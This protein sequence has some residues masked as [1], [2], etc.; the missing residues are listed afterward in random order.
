MKSA[1]NMP[2]PKIH[3]ALTDDWELRGNGSG[4]MRQIQF[5]AIREL[6]RIY[7]TYG[8]RSTF[9]VEV[10]Q[11]LTHRKRQGEFPE[12]GRLADE[13]DE[14]VRDAFK[15]GQ[16]I[17]LHVHPQ[18]SDA[19]YEGGRWTLS[20]DWSLPNY[21]AET[22][23]E[24]LS[25][26][27]KYLEDLLRPVDP[28]Y[29]VVSF[30][31]GSSSIAP[32]DFA[33]GLLVRLGLVFDMSIVGGLRVNTRNL[34]MDYTYCDEDLLPFYPRMD[35][36][37]K[38]S[39]KVEPIVCVPIFH[40]HLSRAQ[41]T[42]QVLAKMGQKVRGKLAN[43]DKRGAPG[44]KFAVDEWAEIG[45]SSRLA[46]LYDKAIKPCLAGKH[47]VAD[48]GQLDY[49]GLQAMI[50]AIRKRGRST[51]LAEVP[52][53]LTNHSK[54][55]KDFSAIERFVSEASKAADIR[56]VTLTQLAENLRAGKFP[57][58]TDAGS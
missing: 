53:I 48:I 30:R 3:L 38:V 21:D 12:L 37:R 55:I 17:Q 45:R 28:A 43:G 7:N 22:A 51:G 46:R 49:P 6:Q 4:D 57:I 44:D 25:A 8:V 36:A 33:L 15:S 23:H 9:N 42:R 13:W 11:Q 29:K 58:R 1:Q 50:A 10:M 18:W 39:E 5:N 56:F 34:S 2:E 47:S 40:F 19:R 54:D 41:A 20:G 24:M 31:A 14:H 27:K 32:S 26:S 16:D 52:I 35:D